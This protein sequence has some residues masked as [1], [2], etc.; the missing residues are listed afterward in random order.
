MASLQHQTSRRGTIR[1]IAL[2]GDSKT[3]RAKLQLNS[4]KKTTYSEELEFSAV[5]GGEKNS[6]DNTFSEATPSATLTMS[7]TNKALHGKFTPGQ[8]FYVDFTE[9][10]A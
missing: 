7:V 4:V 1:T 2:L 5:Y 8:K 3:M 9:A 6:E 10:A